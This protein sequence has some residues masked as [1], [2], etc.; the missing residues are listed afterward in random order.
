MVCDGRGRPLRLHLTEGQRSDHKGAEALIPHLPHAR[1]LI[2]DK[3]YA[4]RWMHQSLEQRAI[5]ACIP[6]QRQR[7]H[8]PEY[9]PVTYRQRHRIE[10]MFAKPKDWR[11]IHT[12]YDRC[13]DIFLAAI[14]FAAI[15]I[16]WINES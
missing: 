14:T 15:F 5:T 11:R 13:A 2:A 8:L 16:F 7:R 6:A 10:N 9:D 1:V 3:A 4:S 12:R